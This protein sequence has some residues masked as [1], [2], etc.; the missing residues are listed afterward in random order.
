M[1]CFYSKLQTFGS[2]SIKV[3]SAKII[4][5]HGFKDMILAFTTRGLSP[6]FR[7]AVF[8][9]GIEDRVKEK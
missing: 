7:S 4:I 5:P 2:L 1:I 8:V 9:L 3:S 6:G